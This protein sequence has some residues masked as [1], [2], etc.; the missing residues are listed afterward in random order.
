[1]VT[2][3]ARWWGGRFGLCPPLHTDALSRRKLAS[4]SQPTAKAEITQAKIR[5]D[6]K[7]RQADMDIAL[8][9]FFSASVLSVSPTRLFYSDLEHAALHMAAR[10]PPN[11]GTC[12]E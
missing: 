5:E 6:G 12:L 11:A 7:D 10:A 8:A 1:M 2:A 3:V 4:K 9:N